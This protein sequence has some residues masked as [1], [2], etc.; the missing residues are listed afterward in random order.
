MSSPKNGWFLGWD[1]CGQVKGDERLRLLASKA[2]RHAAGWRWVEG[3][4]GGCNFS[5]PAGIEDFSN[6]FNDFF[7]SF[8]LIVCNDGRHRKNHQTWCS[9]ACVPGMRFFFL[10]PLIEG[11]K[12]ARFSELP[13]VFKI[14]FWEIMKPK[15]NSSKN[16][17]I[18]LIKLHQY[19]SIYFLVYPSYPTLSRVFCLVYP[20]HFMLLSSAVTHP[21][22]AIAPVCSGR[23]MFEFGLGRVS[24]G[25]CLCGSGKSYIKKALGFGRVKSP[26]LFFPT[27]DGIT[28]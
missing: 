12:S 6:R 13:F 25:I 4:Y 28:L 19:I 23:K 7:R 14:V 10:A 3:G 24:T 2:T 17:L 9:S 5:F 11:R 20:I 15:P 8:G 16:V 21:F 22:V 26:V 18:S 1:Y 27:F